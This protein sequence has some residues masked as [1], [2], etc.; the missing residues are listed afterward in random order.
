MRLEQ[1]TLTD[2]RTLYGDF[3]SFDVQ[4]AIIIGNTHE[5]VLTSSGNVEKRNMGMV[6]IPKSFQLK[7]QLQVRLKIIIVNV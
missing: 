5:E 2:G 6:L 7:V 3:L 4:G 1:V